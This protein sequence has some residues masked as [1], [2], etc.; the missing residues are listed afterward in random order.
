MTRY[1]HADLVALAR[2]LLSDAGMDA[3]QA[4]RVADLL[5]AADAMPGGVIG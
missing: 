1:L 4:P 5:V 3:E 2:D